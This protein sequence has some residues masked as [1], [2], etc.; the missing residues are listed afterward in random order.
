MSDLSLYRITA[1]QRMICEAIDEAGGEITPELEAMLQI[2][3]D[4]MVEKAGDFIEAIKEAEAIEQLA[5]L[6]IKEA[7]A[8]KARM[9]NR[10]QRLKETLKGA[11][12]QFGL[13]RLPIGMHTIGFRRSRAVEITDDAKVPNRYIK[14]STSID[15]AS[16]LADLKDGEVVEGARLVEKRNLAIR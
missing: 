9:K 3:E 5:D 16:L 10:A 2:T 14:V 7:Q 13:E 1:D 4:R 15:K 8:V 11:M 6:R 12:E